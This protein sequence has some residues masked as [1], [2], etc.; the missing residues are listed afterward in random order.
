MPDPTTP[1]LP[2]SLPGSR[3]LRILFPLLQTALLITATFAFMTGDPYRGSWAAVAFALT[4]LPGLLER[5][6]GAAIH[7]G[8]KAAIALALFL[9][10]AG[11][12]YG[13]YFLYYPV[14]DKVAHFT[15]SVAIALMVLLL[16]LF[17]ATFTRI[18]LDRRV[19]VALIIISVLVL[20]AVWEYGE[21][22][23][24]ILIGSTYFVGPYDSTGDMLAN[25]AGAGTVAYMAH[26]RLKGY[27]VETVFRLFVSLPST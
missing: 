12:I 17:M 18:R 7:R 11:G 24:D 10:S 3:G 26:R 25:L 14:Y 27:P 21:L 6:T 22:T 19:M 20:G 2:V 4:F 1:S 16:L 15:S 23:V 9:H 13:W 5:A 8:V